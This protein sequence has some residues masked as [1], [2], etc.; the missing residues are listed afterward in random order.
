MTKGSDMTVTSAVRNAGRGSAISRIAMFVL[1]LGLCLGASGRSEAGDVVNPI[2]ERMVTRLPLV[3]KAI[4]PLTGSWMVV[5]PQTPEAGPSR[6]VVLIIDARS[7]ERVADVPASG[8]VLAAR[9]VTSN[10]KGWSGSGAAMLVQDEQAGVSL[11]ALIGEDVRNLR[12]RRSVI[13]GRDIPRTATLQQLDGRYFAVWDDSKGARSLIVS[14]GGSTLVDVTLDRPVRAILPTGDENTVLAIDDRGASLVALRSGA[15]M[16]SISVADL[17]S[18]LATFA[19]PPG[20]DGNRKLLV[21]N[22]AAEVLTVLTAQGSR[23]KRLAPPAQ[24]MTFDKD[25]AGSGRPLVTATGD[26]Q[27]IL[28]G[29]EGSARVQVFRQI[30]VALERAGALTLDKPIL[31]MIPLPGAGANGVDVFAFLG[32]DRRTVTLVPADKLT[33]ETAPIPT[34]GLKPA[35]SVTTE[36]GLDVQDVLNVQRTLAELGYQV[37]AIDGVLGPATRSAVRAFQLTTNLAVSGEID[38]ETLGA[39]IAAALKG[40]D[41]PDVTLKPKSGSGIDPGN[42]TIYVQFAGVIQREEVNALIALLRRDGWNV[43]GGAERLASAAG[44]NEVRFGPAGDGEAASALA[45]ALNDSKWSG[46]DVRAKRVGVVRPGILEL[47]ISR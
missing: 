34:P 39:I 1:V 33:V 23:M 16:E 12:A 37:G 29:R 46:K 40:D 6:P 24:I 14:S 35:T 10:Q 3:A 20:S 26:L 47:W 2:T 36:E 22:S 9:G 18:P 32:E 42:Y 13:L 45:A 19:S 21:L 44:L 27:S 5:E 17:Q 8:R 4:S 28:V 41:Q 38:P 31:A 43:L 30:G 15:V 25:M 11:E 7:G